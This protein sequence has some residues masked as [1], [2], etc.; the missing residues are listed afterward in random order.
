MNC[1]YFLFHRMINWTYPIRNC[2]DPSEI[3]SCDQ[4]GEKVNLWIVKSL[5]TGTKNCNAESKW[6]SRI[7]PMK[8]LQVHCRLQNWSSLLV[9]ENWTPHL[10]GQLCPL[11]SRYTASISYCK[12]LCDPLI[13]N[14]ISMVSFPNLMLL[15]F[16]S[17]LLNHFLKRVTTQYKLQYVPLLVSS[18]W[19]FDPFLSNQQWQEIVS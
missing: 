19:H 13:G 17:H 14:Q 5:Q 8:F 16:Y 7:L 3:K 1:S 18:S 2:P 11:D 9:L 12:L 4:I 15:K 6:K 10:I